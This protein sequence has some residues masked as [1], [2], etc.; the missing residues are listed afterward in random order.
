VRGQ[1]FAQRDVVARSMQLPPELMLLSAVL[2]QC[3]EDAQSSSDQIRAEALHFLQNEKNVTY[4]DHFL[5]L[6]GRLLREAA[7]LVGQAQDQ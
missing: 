5:G 2:R 3:L 7:A 1:K 4:W 6:D